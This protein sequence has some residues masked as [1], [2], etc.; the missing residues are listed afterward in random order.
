MIVIQGSMRIGPTKSKLRWDYQKMQQAEAQKQFQD[1][2]A[3]LPIPSWSI[4]VDDHSAIIET[5]ILQ[6][7][8]QH[9]GKPKKAKARPLLRESTVNGISLKRQALDMARSCAFADPQLVQELKEIE[10]IV[11]P[12]VIQ[13]QKDWYADWLDGINSAHERHDS[14]Q[15]FKK[16]QRLGKRKKDLNKG[17]RPLPQLRT[18]DGEC[19]KSFVECQQI[20]K[21]QFAN[22]EAG[23]EV[24]ELQLAQMH[25]SQHAQDRRS[26]D[27][28][29][30]PAEILSI[31]RKFK[32]GKVPGPGQ[33]PVD[34]V[35]SGHRN[36]SGF[37]TSHD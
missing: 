32:N 2:I 36:C 9:F 25:L 29:L 37:G 21:K 15:V 5:N 8:Q 10:K 17:P 28:C 31:I 24:S 26:P 13:D 18:K 27:G 30:T 6:L 1:A 35:K 34:V 12:M 19:A 14:A 20:W 22:I 11:R 3:T 33:L 7:A 23:V 16:L 4:S